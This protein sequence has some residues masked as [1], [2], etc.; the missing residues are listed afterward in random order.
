[1]DYV[2]RGTIATTQL[3]PLILHVLQSTNPDNTG[4]D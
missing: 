4:D 1:M 3:A 2:D